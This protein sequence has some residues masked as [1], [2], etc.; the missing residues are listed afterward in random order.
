MR[1]VLHSDLSAAARV[2]LLI[3]HALRQSVMDQ[4]VV[5]AEFADRHMRRLKAPHPE[6]GSGTL[7]AAAARHAQAD[8]P[9][10]DSSEY[11]ECLRIVLRS[12]IA[13]RTRHKDKLCL[14]R[15]GS[16]YSDLE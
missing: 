14:E 6:W 10:M 3:P 5:D 9:S 8:E 4:M 1:P 2:L 7:A 16:G 15:A 11:C 13:R 12:L